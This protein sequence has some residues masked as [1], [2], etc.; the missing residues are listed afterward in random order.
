MLDFDFRP[1]TPADVMAAFA[2][3]KQGGIGPDLPPPRG[4][5]ETWEL[6]W[7]YPWDDEWDPNPN[8]GVP[9]THDWGWALAVEYPQSYLELTRPSGS[10]LSWDPKRN[11]WHWS[12]LGVIKADPEEYLQLVAWIGAF[13][14]PGAT[15]SLLVPAGQ[16]RYDP[17]PIPIQILCD[18]SRFIAPSIG[19]L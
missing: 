14:C 17:D 11:V 2:S 4:R 12:S 6:D 9:W 5:D 15:E 19:A 1:D 7:D 18:G 8:P 10:S 13:A 3:A 16:L